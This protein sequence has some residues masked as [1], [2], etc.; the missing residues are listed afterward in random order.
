MIP[1]QTTPIYGSRVLTRTKNRQQQPL[2]TRGSSWAGHLLTFAEP[3]GT[4]PVL[5]AYPR[6][7]Q[8]HLLMPKTAACSVGA[9]CTLEIDDP[10]VSNS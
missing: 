2:G 1:L 4:L 3:Q 9:R 6:H 8:V 7:R 5:P 10:Y